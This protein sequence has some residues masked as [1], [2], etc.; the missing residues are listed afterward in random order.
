MTI[1]E[2]LCEPEVKQESE[3]KETLAD[4]VGNL[5][6]VPGADFWILCPC[7]GQFQVPR[8]M[9]PT[10]NAC[11]SLFPCWSASF[12]SRMGL[13]SRKSEQFWRAKD[14]LLLPL[15]W[16]SMEKCPRLSVLLKLNSK[17]HFIWFLRRCP[18]KSEPHL[19]TL[20]TYLLLYPSLAFLPARA[21]RK[22]NSVWISDKQW[23]IYLV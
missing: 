10:L 17:I 11:F 22:P 23:K 6:H 4:S 3:W 20:I 7:G 19:S 5:R 15:W 16:E 18:A 1:T 9:L 21:A 12:P 8:G 14:L 2:L 13:L